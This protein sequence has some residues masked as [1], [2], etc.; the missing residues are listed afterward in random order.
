MTRTRMHEIAIGGLV[1]ASVL[2]WIGAASVEGAD[3]EKS[4][5]LSY[6]ICI[7]ESVPQ[8]PGYGLSKK[9]LRLRCSTVAN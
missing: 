4:A 5:D 6:R 2:F 9:V 7:E 8:D 3:G 1:S